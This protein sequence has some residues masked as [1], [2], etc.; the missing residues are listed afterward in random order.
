MP[1]EKKSA[2]AASR[3]ATKQARGSSII[4][5]DEVVLAGAQAVALADPLDERAQLDQLALCS[6]PAGS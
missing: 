1:K 3:S 2:A 5:P 6:R 4:V